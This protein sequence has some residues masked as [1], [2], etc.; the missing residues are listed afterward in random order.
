MY[1]NFK[2]CKREFVIVKIIF[3]YNIRPFSFIHCSSLVGNNFQ[4]LIPQMAKLREIIYRVAIYLRINKYSRI[5]KYYFTSTKIFNIYNIFVEPQHFWVSQKKKLQYIIKIRIYFLN[6]RQI[7]Y[8]WNSRTQCSS[9][10]HHNWYI[11][12][13]MVQRVMTT[14][15]LYKH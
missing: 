15:C 6:S 5:S 7:K 14:K 11:V 1:F 12:I 13:R 8:I 3:N 4:I 9:Y 10:E 2:S